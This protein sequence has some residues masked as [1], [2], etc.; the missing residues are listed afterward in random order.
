MLE[1]KNLSAGYNGAKILN[2][3]D[4]RL[5]NSEIVG[6]IG[7]NGSG[8]STIFKSIFNICDVYEGRILLDGDNIIKKS[9][10]KMISLGLN[11]VIQGAL[12]FLDLTVKENLEMGG[13]TINNKVIL[14]KKIEKVLNDFN[15]LKS[16]LHYYAHTLSGGQRQMLALARSLIVEP[17]ILL[18][19]EPSAGISPTN[20]SKIFEKILEINNQGIAIMIIEQNTKAV[21]EIANTIYKIDD[22][23]VTERY[24]NKKS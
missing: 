16:K 15:F 8:K 11:Y 10:Y 21:F 23:Q 24:H 14:E 18:L 20:I 9:T 17:R 2:G 13:F 3:V 1:I 4:L 12:I 5:G 19:D 6:I 22:G 7:P